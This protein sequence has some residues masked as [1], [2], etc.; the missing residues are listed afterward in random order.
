LGLSLSL[1]HSTGR[2]ETVP[3]ILLQMYWDRPCS[4]TQQQPQ[5]DREKELKDLERKRENRNSKGL[6]IAVGGWIV[7][8]LK[9]VS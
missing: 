8:W 5:D 9:E 2:T 1:Q 3:E 6:S 4:L 7:C